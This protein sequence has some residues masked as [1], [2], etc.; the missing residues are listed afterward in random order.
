MLKLSEKIVKNKVLILILAFLLLI[1]AGIGYITT[2]INYDLLSYLPSNIETMKGQDILKDEFGT[3]AFSMYVVKGMGE[4]DISNLK[5]KIEDVKGVKSVLW[6]DDVI[7][8]SI[9]SEMLPNDVS[10]IFN[11]KEKDEKMMIIFYSGSTSEDDTIK[12][13]EQIRKVSNKEC[14]LGSMSAVVEDTKILSNQETPIYVGIA[15]ILTL[16]VLGVCLDS[17]YIPFIFLLSIGMSIVYNLGS[18]IFLG[19]ISY[20]TKALAAV[21]QL[22]VT[23]DYSIFLYHRYKE[24]QSNFENKNEAMAHA[25]TN[26]FISIA[27]SS[28]TTVAG[29]LALCFMTFTLGLDLGIVMAKG[30]VFGIITCVTILPSLLL[31]LDKRIEKKTHKPLLP[32]LSNVS[33]I[34]VKHYKKFAILFIIILIPA[35]YGY[36]HT[37]VYYNLDATLP[38]SLESIAANDKLEKDFDMGAAHVVLTDKSLSKKDSYLM[39]QKMKDIDGVTHVLGTSSLL[40]PSV[41]DEFI[42]QKVKDELEG[43][44]YNL[45]LVTSSYKT[46]TTEVNNQITKLN[47][48]VKGYSSKSMLIGE[49]PCT[50]DL[51]DITN[52][53]FKVVSVL[54][55]G[56]ILLIVAVVFKSISI[57]IILVSI[58]EFA[59]FINM[60]IPCYTKTV[61]PF[62]ASIVIGTI[63]LGSTVDYAILLTTRYKTERASGLGKE[64]SIK[65]ATA[66]SVNSIVTSASGFFFATLGVALYSKIDFIASLCTLLSRGALISMLVVIFMLPT[67]LMIFDKLI[68]KTSYKF[69]DNKNETV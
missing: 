19:Q 15:A 41:P 53:D 47:K 2:R 34:V 52:K 4:K 8:V 58:I 27:G 36:T 60:G 3:G 45:T 14:L 33:N 37:D 39:C 66:T 51:I 18:N 7:D 64:E 12:A 24:E 57:P 35:L 56:V 13:V 69:F 30:V 25:I 55:I 59:I 5:G 61:I 48:I 16:I 46:G 28:I 23:M 17:F 38:K 1:P 44:N 67:A 40:D 20:L 32:D 11:N 26:T 42:P 10:K 31:V 65:I 50:K 68:I 6:A 62:I 49:A 22:A 29:F 63:Q 21:L 43:D 9:P 54:S